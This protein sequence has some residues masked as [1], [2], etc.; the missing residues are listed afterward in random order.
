MLDETMV[1]MSAPW[2]IYYRKLNELFGRDKDIRIEYDRDSYEIKLYVDNTDKA[3]ALGLLLPDKKEFGG[4]T[5]TI[6]VIP[7][8]RPHDNATLI[9]TAFDGNPA[10]M[11][12]DSK[13]I[14][15]ATINY[16]L[17]TDRSASYYSDDISEYDGRTY[18]F[19]R[20]LARD[21]I[22]NL[23]DIHFGTCKEWV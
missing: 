20:D 15:G 12:I 2:D 9:A 14:L 23:D 8:N 17:F 4:V 7:F 5:L 22:G 11:G 3:N 19:Y 6:N 13:E 10:F 1:K 16:A 21:V 18:V